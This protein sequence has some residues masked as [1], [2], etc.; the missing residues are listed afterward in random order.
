MKAGINRWE[1]QS[2]ILTT[3]SRYI[4]RFQE[5]ATAPL[6]SRLGKTPN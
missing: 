6:R 5:A 2:L 3:A 1:S 4:A